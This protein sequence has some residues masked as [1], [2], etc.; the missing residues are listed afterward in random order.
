M[1]P[2]KPMEPITAQTVLTA[3]NRIT[4]KRIPEPDIP[5][6]PGRHPFILEKNS[7]IPGKTILETP[8]LVVGNP[9]KPIATMGIGMTLT[10]SMIE[11]AGALGLDAILV[12]HP[13]ADA[14]SSGG[15]PL[16]SYLELYK[17]ALFELHEAFH[18]LHPGIAFLHGHTVLEIDH[19]FGG[20][21]GNIIFSGKS[22]PEIQSANDIIQRLNAFMD[23][24]KEREVLNMEMKIRDCASMK[25]T[26][27]TAVPKILSGTLD[28][29]VKHVL[30]IFPHTGF[31]ARHLEQALEQYPETDTIITSISRVLE[32][33]D[34]VSAARSMGLT[35]IIGNSHAQEIF[36][37]GLP[38]AWALNHE[39]THLELIMLRERVTALPLKEFGNRKIQD[40]GQQMANH[41]TREKKQNKYSNSRGVGL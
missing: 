39:L 6:E 35:M 13:V 38:L 33:S 41:L 7:G 16:K 22:L 37:N 11:L 17:L 27:L 3:L 9:D 29:P 31:T 21:P 34:M 23:V 36:E 4:G 2:L 26:A 28:S 10:E 14:A 30:H 18:G 8:G 25:E 15:V 5:K 20:I 12:H 24:E 40:Y 32:T 1:I 19:R